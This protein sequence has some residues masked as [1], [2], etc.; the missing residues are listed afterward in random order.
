MAVVGPR[1]VPICYCH[2]LAP[3]LT[4]GE[5][6]V[7]LLYMQGVSALILVAPAVIAPRLR[8]AARRPPQQSLAPR[9]APGHLSTGDA[10][11][12]SVHLRLRTLKCVMHDATG[13]SLQQTSRQGLC[14]NPC[15]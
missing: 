5:V 2:D 6:N 15:C 8:Q 3:C 14:H 10:F 11:L 13:M 1:R 7:T 12:L 9:Q 4:S